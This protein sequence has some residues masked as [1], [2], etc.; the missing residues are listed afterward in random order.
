MLT[1]ISNRYMEHT[2]A[3]LFTGMEHFSAVIWIDDCHP[4]LP[5]KNVWPREEFE[6]SGLDDIIGI[7]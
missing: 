1:G 2:W 4:E 5:L 7:A 6:R 3:S